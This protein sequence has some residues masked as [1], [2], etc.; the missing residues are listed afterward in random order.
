MLS[1]LGLLAIAVTQQLSSVDRAQMLSTVWLEA[2]YNYAYWDQ[3]Q[4]DWDSAYRATLDAA[5]HRSTDYVFYRSLQR[6]VALLNDGHTGTRPPPFLA[7]RIA[8]PPIEIQT[9]EG[10]PILVAFARTSELRIANPRIGSEIVS[11]QGVPTEDW[12]R[13][14]ILPFIGGSTASDRWQRAVSE[15]LVGERGTALQLSI[16]LPGGDVRGVSLTRSVALS[17]RWPLAHPAAERRRLEGNTVLLRVNSL[18]SD[19]TLERVD[20]ALREGGGARALIL[21]F[22][23]AEGGEAELAYQILARLTDKPFMTA[24]RRSRAYRAELRAAGGADPMSDWRAWVADTLAPRTDPAPFLGPVA[25]LTSSRTSGAAEDFVV[26]FRHLGRGAI[27]GEPTAGAAGDV[28]SIRLPQ[29]GTFHVTITRRAFPN[30]SEFVG[31]GI[32]P[33]VPVETRV[34]DL[35]RGR[36]PAVERASEVLRALRR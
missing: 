24:L 34:E 36:D 35:V 32:D 9:V 12:V 25:V 22:R 31:R 15:M 17:D 28:V 2:R 14:S 33:E 18:S 3:V 8:R 7:Q 4:A 26:A 5:L 11:V 30:G 10:R 21:D 16:R 19:E 23:E 29:G 6:M 13:D 1:P 20:E 27:V